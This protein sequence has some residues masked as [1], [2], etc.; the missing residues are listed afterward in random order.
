MRQ[1]KALGYEGAL[2][3][4]YSHPVI[5]LPAFSGAGTAPPPAPGA[6]PDPAGI[7]IQSLCRLR[8]GRVRHHAGDARQC[9]GA[10]EGG[11]SARARR[12]SWAHP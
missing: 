8:R 5:T 11:G 4:A 12:L 7:G 2:V 1:A 9:D 10:V 3:L 6:G